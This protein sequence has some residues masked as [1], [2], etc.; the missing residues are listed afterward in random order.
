MAVETL[1]NLLISK[2]IP[3]HCL[4]MTQFE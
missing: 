3:P 2:R 4:A 1:M